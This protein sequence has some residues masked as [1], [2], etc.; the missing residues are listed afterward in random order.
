MPLFQHPG[1]DR[2]VKIWLYTE[3]LLRCSLRGRS[4]GVII[5]DVYAAAVESISAE[6]EED[7]MYTKLTCRWHTE[8]GVLGNL[9]PPLC[10]VK[11]FAIFFY[12]TYDTYVV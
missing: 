8:L 5:Q 9:S 10:D 3:L 12:D 6:E 11:L 4:G 2:W 1:D 7:V